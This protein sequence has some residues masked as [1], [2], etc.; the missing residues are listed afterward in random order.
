MKRKSP[1]DQRLDWLLPLAIAEMCNETGPAH[2]LT[3]DDFLRADRKFLSAMG[4]CLPSAG[5]ETKAS[6]ISAQ[7]RE[8]L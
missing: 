6:E 8:A 1:Q 4:I 2:A 7:R 5:R 3:P